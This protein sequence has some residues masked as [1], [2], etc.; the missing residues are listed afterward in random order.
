MVQRQSKFTNLFTFIQF[1]LKQLTFGEGGGYDT[2]SSLLI[3]LSQ[4]FPRQY[5]IVV[6]RYSSVHI[7]NDS[8]AINIHAGIYENIMQN[9]N[10]NRL[11]KNTVNHGYHTIELEK[12]KKSMLFYTNCSPKRRCCFHRFR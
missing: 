5:R 8:N 9:N 11:H 4:V 2:P 3:L 10:L 7:I 1:T 6:F 12:K